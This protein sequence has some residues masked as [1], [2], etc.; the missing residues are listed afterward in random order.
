M[1]ISKSKKIKSNDNDPRLNFPGKVLLIC[2]VIA[3]SFMLLTPVISKRIETFDTPTDYRIPYSLSKDYSLYQRYL[4]RMTTNQIPILGDSVVWGEYVKPDG[5]LSHFLNEQASQP[6]LFINAG[7]NGLFPLALEGLLHYYG[8]P[9]SHH[10]VIIHCNLLWMTSAESDLSSPKESKFNHVSLVP[11]FTPNI[12]C[13]N[14]KFNDRMSIVITRQSTF[15][16]WV[17][18]IQNAYFDQKNLYTW[19]LADNGKYPPSYPNAAKNPFKQITFK[20]PKEPKYDPDRGPDSPRHKP[21]STTGIG[22]QKFPWVAL[23]KSL[24]WKSFQRTVQYLKKRENKVLVIIGPFNRHI[25]ALENQLEF[26]KKI[27]KIQSWLQKQNIPFITPDTLKSDLYCDSSHPL[28][29]G[30][31][32]LAKNIAESPVYKKWLKNKPF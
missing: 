24:Q 32:Q 15:F 29:Q 3:I 11:Q 17:N 26:D 1:T 14:A 7:V 6:D 22:T 28:T 16:S 19:T 31:Y 27:K 4:E 25:M 20:V 2:S 8:K 9:I 18:H 30:Y 21:W 13:Y 10:K 23:E 12:P 5:T